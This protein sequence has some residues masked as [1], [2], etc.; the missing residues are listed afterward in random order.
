MNGSQA[1]IL[2]GKVSRINNVNDKSQSKQWLQNHDERIGGHEMSSR[3]EGIRTNHQKGIDGEV[4]DQKQHEKDAGDA[5]YEFFPNRRGKKMAHRC[6]FL[7]ILL[8]LQ[9]VL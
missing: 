7:L 1:L 3:I 9:L 8:I 2:Q 4:D 5:H 6:G